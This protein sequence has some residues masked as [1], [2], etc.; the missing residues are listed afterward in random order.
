MLVNVKVVDRA[1]GKVDQN[2]T[3]GTAHG[4]VVLHHASVVELNI[5]AEEVQS[6]RREGADLVLHLK[7]GQEIVINNFFVVSGE[8]SE[9]VFVSDKGGFDWLDMHLANVPGEAAADG[10][11]IAGGVDA[12]PVFQHISDVSV[13]L[14]AGSSSWQDWAPLALLGLGVAGAGIGAAVASGGGGSAATVPEVQV[15]APTAT[16]TGNP[17]GTVTIAGTG[18]P[19][20]TVTV[21]YADG[22]TGTAK[23]AAD[24]TYAITSPT[25]EA[26]GTINVTDTVNGQTSAPTQI[27]YTDGVA[28]NPPN[29]QIIGNGE[30]TVT[31]SGIA[32]PG[33]TVTVTYPDGTTGSTRVAAD[34]SYAITSP[35][36][37]ANGMISV[38]DTFNGQTSA[39]TQANYVDGT[40][41]ASPET[42]ATGN[43]DGTVTVA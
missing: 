41:P 7:D 32:V 18:V 5:H 3:I 26:I 42:T 28:P 29:A 34:G 21:T 12:Q 36:P 27:S 13:L 17:D 6:Y 22:T 24:G 19:G 14:D 25:P 38:T 1:D 43:P 15:A 20:G 11:S 16:A 33:S 31:I 39:P 8:R 35:T 2:L 9:I 23:V 40:A 10:S 30:G 37:E 4:V